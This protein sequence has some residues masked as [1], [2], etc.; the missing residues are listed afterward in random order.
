MADKIKPDFDDEDNRIYDAASEPLTQS[1]EPEA[2]ASKYEEKFTMTSELLN[3]ILRFLK[4]TFLF[5]VV[6]LIGF[7]NLSFAWILLVTVLMLLREQVNRTRQLKL[8]VKREIALDEKKVIKAAVEH[9][10]SWVHFP[11]RERAEWLNKVRESGLYVV[12][13]LSHS[14]NRSCGNCGRSSTIMRRRSCAK[15]WN[16]R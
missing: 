6:W 9:L 13:T 10:P 11:D 16:R 5:F 3:Q 12:D 15:A 14:V 1:A 2:E 4:Y 7:F 8:S